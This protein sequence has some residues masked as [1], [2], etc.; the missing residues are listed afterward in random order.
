VEQDGDALQLTLLGRACGRSTLPF[1]SVMKLVDLLGRIGP[2]SLTPLKLMALLQVIPESDGGYTP[3]IK[4]GR[5]S[6]SAGARRRRAIIYLTN[7]R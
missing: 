3:M 4:R 1:G 2:A 7:Q 5:R 6:P